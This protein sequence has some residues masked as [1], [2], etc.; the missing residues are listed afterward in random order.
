M[1]GLENDEAKVYLACLKLGTQDANTI[2]KESKFTRPETIRILKRLLN[3][4]LA[5]EFDTGKCFYLVEEPAKLPEI[6]GRFEKISTARKGLF[7]KALPTLLQYRDPNFTKPE[8]SYYE[9]K[10]GIIAAYEDTLTS[11]N[12]ILA[13]A[14]IDDTESTFPRYVPLYYKRRKAAGILIKAIFPDTEMARK[15]QGSDSEELR[16]SRLVPLTSFDFTFEINIYDDKVAFFS[17]K[18]KIALIIKSADI[19]SSMRSMFGLCWEM[20]AVYNK[21]QM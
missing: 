18:E 7:E 14:S 9:G 13:L 12:E 3:K 19:A 15:R 1:I 6:M 8:I 11:K 16:I 2:S 10:E 5:Q 17:L 4:G 21:N 20:A